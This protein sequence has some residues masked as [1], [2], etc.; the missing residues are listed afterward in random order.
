MGIFRIRP[1]L[2]PNV[3]HCEVLYQ[4]LDLQY[5]AHPVLSTGAVQQPLC[6]LRKVVVPQKIGDSAMKNQVEGHV[7]MHICLNPRASHDQTLLAVLYDNSLS[8]P[9]SFVHQH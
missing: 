5:V 4:E 1:C 7:Q 9:R 2:A 8:S 3:S 6:G